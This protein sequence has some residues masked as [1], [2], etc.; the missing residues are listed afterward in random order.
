MWERKPEEQEQPKKEQRPHARI[1]SCFMPSGVF[2]QEEAKQNWWEDK[3]TFRVLSFRLLVSR[4]AGQ[5][6]HKPGIFEGNSYTAQSSF[7]EA[8][9]CPTSNCEVRFRDRKSVPSTL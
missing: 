9:H 8:L 3:A 7:A 6:E 2:L 4:G 5:S 1:Q